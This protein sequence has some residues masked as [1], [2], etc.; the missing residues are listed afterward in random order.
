MDKN[1]KIN[2]IEKDKFGDISKYSPIFFTVDGLK[3]QMLL[4]NFL[5]IYKK[6]EEVQN[7]I[8]PNKN[9]NGIRQLPSYKKYAYA[10]V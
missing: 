3:K 7:F 8:E 1:I 4:K 9:K 2:K 6:F 10:M 5:N